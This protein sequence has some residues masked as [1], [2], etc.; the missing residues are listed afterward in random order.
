MFTVRFP[1]PRI[2]DDAIFYAAQDKL[3]RQRPINTPPRIVRSA[4]LLTAVAKCGACGAP[5]RL[6]TG[7]SGA[8]RYYRCS[9]KADSGASA[10]KGVSIPMGELDGIVLD[11][12]EETVLEPKR[13]RKMTEALV[14]R[15]S[16]RNEAFATRQR[17][18]DILADNRRIQ[19]T[20]PGG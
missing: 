1:V 17:Q 18:L 15:A 4:V 16:E 20:L 12:L 11:A 19:N 10:C 2:I 6:Q 5:L 13:L 9:A 7:Q 3:D 8:Y 14:S